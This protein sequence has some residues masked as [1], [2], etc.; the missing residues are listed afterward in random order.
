MTPVEAGAPEQRLD[1]KLIDTPGFSDVVVGTEG[2][3]KAVLD[4]V[5]ARLQRHA[6]EC[7]HNVRNCKDRSGLVHVCVFFL[8]PHR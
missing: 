1:V 6:A 8:G 3:F 5:E 4:E 2:S 7:A